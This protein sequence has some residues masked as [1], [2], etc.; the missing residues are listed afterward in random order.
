MKKPTQ[1]PIDPNA[2]RTKQ[3]KQI[4]MPQIYPEAMNDDLCS[5]E[6]LKKHLDQ[7][8]KILDET[9]HEDNNENHS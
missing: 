7:I 3:V 4:P 1:T 2:P 5:S 8:N 9:A 6:D